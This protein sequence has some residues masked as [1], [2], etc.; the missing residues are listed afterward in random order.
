MLGERRRHARELEEL[1]HHA[2]PEPDGRDE[3]RGGPGPHEGDQHDDERRVQRVARRAAGRRGQQRASA[4][5]R[6]HDH[7]REQEEHGPRTHLPTLAGTY[8]D[9]MPSAVA[10]EQDVEAFARQVT[11]SLGLGDG[12]AQAL[13][14]GNENHAVRA[15]TG[16]AD[17]VVRFTRDPGRLRGDTFDVEAWCAGAAARAGIRT[18][19]VVART[20]IE[21]ES[22]LVVEHVTG[23]ATAADDLAAW[24]AIGAAAARL[25]EVGTDDAPDGLFSRFGRDLDAAWDAHLVYNLDA[26]GP[27]DALPGLGVYDARDRDGLR[28]VVASLRGRDLRQGLVHGDLCHR[29]LVTASDGGYVVLDWGS[30]QVGPRPWTDVEQIHRWHVTRD[31]ETPVSA[32]AWDEVLGAVLEGTGVSPDAAAGIV[33][34]LAVL[35]ALDVVRWA[36]DRRPDRLAELATQSAATVRRE[37]PL[38]VAG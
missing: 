10:P 29:N 5:P 18:A 27:D 30:A 22:V 34:S 3:P 36:Q 24:R 20:H 21:G 7:S 2:Q 17:V 28:D 26:L 11:R 38:L 23:Q 16:S 12:T 25:A 32:A 6:E 1:D 35:H 8:R 14:G 37:L 15:R 4:E 13:A 19:P 33:G 31:A 9:S